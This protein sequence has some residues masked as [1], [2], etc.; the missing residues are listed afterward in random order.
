MDMRR[1]DVFLKGSFD[2]II[3]KGT[4]SHAPL[5]SQNDMTKSHYSGYQRY[6]RWRWGALLTLSFLYGRRSGLSLCRI[7]LY[8][9]R[10]L[11]TAGTSYM[12]IL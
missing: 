3:D 7:Q 11:G 2:I 5:P 6:M 4:R 1:M 10:P 12:C 8:L 9:G